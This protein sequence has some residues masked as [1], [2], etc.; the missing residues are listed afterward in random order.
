MHIRLQP[1]AQRTAASSAL[2]AARC[3]REPPC[4]AAWV[5]AAA[6]IA[7]CSA[8]VRTHA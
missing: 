6:S 4:A 7:Q 1:H 3:P 5:A 2:S 8:R